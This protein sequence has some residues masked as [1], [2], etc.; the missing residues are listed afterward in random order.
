MGVPCFDATDDDFGSMCVFRPLP[1]PT[2]P[3]YG[4]A[5][6][7]AARHNNAKQPRNPNLNTIL[8]I[9]S[10]EVWLVMFASRCHRRI[11]RDLKRSSRT[12]AHSQMLRCRFAKRQAKLNNEQAFDIKMVWRGVV[13]CGVLWCGVVWCAVL[14]CGVLWCGVLWCAVVWRGVAWCGGL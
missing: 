8:E 3:K 12:A 2:T 11:P 14:W 7:K 13:W 10:R 5:P 1:T 4:H 6:H 9:L